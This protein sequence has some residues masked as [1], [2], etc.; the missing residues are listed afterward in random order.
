MIFRPFFL[1]LLLRYMWPIAFKHFRFDYT[2]IAIE[3]MAF[4][5]F[6]C[7]AADDDTIVV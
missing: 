7:L 2:F 1:R 4:F 6:Q 5:V 3:H